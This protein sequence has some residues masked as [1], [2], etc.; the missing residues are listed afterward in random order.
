MGAA[1]LTSRWLTGTAH[2]CAFPRHTPSC[3][4][5]VTGGPAEK[6]GRH[7]RFGVSWQIIP[8]ALMRLMGDKDPA[9]AGRVVQA[10][11]G[12]QKLDIAA[13]ERAYAGS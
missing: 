7:D 10:M 13:L 1:G 12:M 9:K 6:N 8:T 5:A 3:L 2:R 11:L 4:L